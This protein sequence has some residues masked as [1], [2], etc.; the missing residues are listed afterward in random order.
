MHCYKCLLF[1]VVQV[2]SQRRNCYWKLGSVW[3]S[4][5]SERCLESVS[6]SNSMYFHMLITKRARGNI[7]HYICCDAP[8]SN[9]YTRE[10]T[11]GAEQSRGGLSLSF[12]TAPGSLIKAQ[13]PEELS[14]SIWTLHTA[15][16]KQLFVCMA[17]AHLVPYTGIRWSLLMRACRSNLVLELITHSRSLFEVKY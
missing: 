16:Q 8:A 1:A 5:Q 17:N 13:K 10:E 4:V 3:P 9:Y 14:G 15:N 7:L 6:N 11:C 12:T 2:L